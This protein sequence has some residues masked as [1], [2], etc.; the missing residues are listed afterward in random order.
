MEGPAQGV[1][2]VVLSG[3]LE[4]TNN[5]VTIERLQAAAA[6]ATDVQVDMSAVGFIDSA[7]VSALLQARRLATGH[8]R[9]LWVSPMSQDVRRA[10][11]VMGLADLLARR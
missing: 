7:A 6:A 11:E 10:L 5:A 8:G 1:I 3:D 9:T 2:V 4:Y